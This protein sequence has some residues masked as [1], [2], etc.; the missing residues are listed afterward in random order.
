[1]KPYFLLLIFLFFYQSAA[2]AQDTT[3]R[4]DR[5]LMQNMQGRSKNPFSDKISV[6][7][8]RQYVDISN[9]YFWNCGNTPIQWQTRRGW[10]RKQYFYLEVPIYRAHLHNISRLMPVCSEKDSNDCNSPFI[11]CGFAPPVFRKTPDFAAEVGATYQENNLIP[12]LA[13]STIFN[14]SDRQQLS[15]L[16]GAD[17]RLRFY[18][19]L[20]YQYAF[21]L[22][23]IYANSDWGSIRSVRIAENEMR[24]Y[25][26]TELT[27]ALAARGDSY[28]R[29]D[30]HLGASYSLFDCHFIVFAQAGASINYLNLP[31][32]APQLL[33]TF[34]LKY[35]L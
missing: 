34:G 29:Q 33:A 11:K 23:P 27:T 16:V 7:V 3:Q 22:L 13:A 10:R 21:I 30:L 35:V 18:G 4:I 26:G 9:L 31:N 32:F 2:V 12:Y 28:L 6:R 25:I 8:P 15:F 5:F 24:F 17:S 20:R 1:M 14:I 19:A